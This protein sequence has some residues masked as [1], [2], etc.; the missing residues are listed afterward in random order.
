VMNH[1]QIEQVDLRQSSIMTYRALQ[2]FISVIRREVLPDDP[3]VGCEELIHDWQTIP[4]HVE[5]AAWVVWNQEKDSLIGFARV[6]L[7]LD[8]ANQH[9][10]N[11]EIYVLPTL[12]RQGIGRQ[13]L[14]RVEKHVQNRDRHTLIGYSNNR[15]PAG[16][17][18]MQA[19][20]AE[21]VQE[22]R[23]IELR[24]PEV[25]DST[26]SSW[27]EHSKTTLPQIE[28]GYWDT[29]YPEELLQQITDLFQV[30][31]NETPRDSINSH[32]TVY[33]PELVRQFEDNQLSGNRKRSVVY[34]MDTVERRIV[35][36]TMVFCSPDRPG[37]LKQGFTGVLPEYRCNGLGRRLKAEMYHRVLSDSPGAEVIRAEVANSNIA[38]QRINDEMGFHP[39]VSRYFWQVECAAIHSYLSTE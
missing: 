2:E 15:V 7:F 3:A 23:T 14:N 34:A 22:Y 39:Y 18:F 16:A 5:V 26:M 17:A 10:V 25:A 30:V 6:D 28:I 4:A 13:L 37:V 8:S 9:L 31:A 21:I 11:F 27:I 1:L 38:M 33:T 20:H 36:L 32:D 19:I 24:L 29:A 35:A 12:R